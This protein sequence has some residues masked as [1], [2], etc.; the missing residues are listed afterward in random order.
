MKIKITNIHNT[1]A[2]M[3]VL[4]FLGLTIKNNLPW[5][6]HL[7]LLSSELSKVPSP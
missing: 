1:I 4:K 3:N 2:N 6:T 5:R 7:D